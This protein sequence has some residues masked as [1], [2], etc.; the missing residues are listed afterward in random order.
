[1][2]APSVLTHDALRLAHADQGRSALNSIAGRPS[3]LLLFTMNILPAP[4]RFMLGLCW[5][6]LA[7]LSLP[8]TSQAE[9]PAP[10]RDAQQF[11]INFLIGMIDHHYSAVK[12]AELCADRAEH[13]ELLAMCDSIKTTQSA[14]IATMQGWLQSWYGVTH[15]PELHGK[16]RRQ[17][18]ALAALEGAAFEQAFMIAMAYHHAEALS[19]A[20][21]CL[22]MAYHPEM[23]GMCAMMA[24]MQGEEIAMLRLWLMQWYGVTD[25]R[26]RR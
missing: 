22:V 9:G 16:M 15:E 20:K 25:L 14:E 1:M 8:V 19:E 23:I 5:S 7:S 4:H 18:E 11:E 6:L 17:I 24:G 12:M 26:L 2:A 13:A 21:D 10:Q 3:G